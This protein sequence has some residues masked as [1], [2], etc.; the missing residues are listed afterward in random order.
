[1]SSP[2]SSHE[3]KIKINTEGYYSNNKLKRI[4]ERWN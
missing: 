1:M 2:K 3:G 4:N